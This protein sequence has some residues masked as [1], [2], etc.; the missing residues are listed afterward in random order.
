[1]KTLHL[2]IE[3]RVQGVWFRESMRRE[4]DRLDVKGWVRNQPDGS[5]EALVQGTHEAVDALLDWTRIGPPMAQVERI[6]QTE[7]QGQYSTFEKWVD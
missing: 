7:A 1:M 4:A 6:T 2:R 5:V 3:G